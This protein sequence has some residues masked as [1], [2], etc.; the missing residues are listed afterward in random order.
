MKCFLEKQ[1]EI[2]TNMIGLGLSKRERERK[3]D[4]GS[5]K[6]KKNCKQE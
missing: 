6:R 2:K 4:R 3:R 1:D 5:E